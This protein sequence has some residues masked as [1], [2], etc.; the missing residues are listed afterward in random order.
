[1]KKGSLRRG[2]DLK[3]PM[4]YFPI[5]R[6]A[7]KA[8]AIDL[9]ALAFVS[10]EQ[11]ILPLYRDR[12]HSR[13]A[14]MNQLSAYCQDNFHNI[15]VA[16]MDGEIVG[17]CAR[18]SNKAYVPYL[19]VTPH[20]QGQGI[21]GLLLKRM[22]NIFELQGYGAVQ[23]ETPADHVQAVRFYENQGYNILAMKAEG[24]NAHKPFMSVR[25]E[26]KLNPFTEQ[27]DDIE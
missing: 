3:R 7:D 10:W 22:E 18:I 14:L 8:E 2:I 21:G 6:H 12:E 16:K 26:K 17:W 20:L 25:L 23:L 11:G 24:H 5:I 9:A 15:I 13:D 27:I 4:T 19:F 1:M